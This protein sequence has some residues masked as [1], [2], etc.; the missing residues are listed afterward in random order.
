MLVRWDFYRRLAAW[1]GLAALLT[2]SACSTNV[3]PIPPESIRPSANA[4]QPGARRSIIG[5]ASWYGPGFDGHRTSTGRIYDQEE[6]TAASELF[7]PGSRVMVTN[8][9]S[10]KSVEVTIT[11]HGPYK[12]GRKIDLSHK[13]AA[14]LGMVQPGT[15]HVLIELVSAPPGSRPVGS[16]PEFFVQVGSFT[17]QEHA[18]Q[19]RDRVAAHFKDVRINQ[20][21]AGASRYYR[22]RMGA[23]ASRHEAEARAADTSRLGIHTVIVCE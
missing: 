17:N 14:I 9:D 10:G 8:L 11:D 7:A 19:I 4:I 16:M 21:D 15:A 3:A 12:K 1:I 2:L 13:A 20:V 18:I 23:F 22:V 6:L 5:V